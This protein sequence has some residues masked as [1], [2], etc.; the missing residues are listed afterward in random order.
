MK[1]A[2]IFGDNL[3]IGEKRE[4]PWAICPS[5]IEKIIEDRPQNLR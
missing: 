4:I 3:P 5:E 2:S 1:I